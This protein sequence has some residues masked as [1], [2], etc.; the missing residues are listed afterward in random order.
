MD[1]ELRYY[2]DPVLRRKAAKVAR[3]DDEVRELVLG[4]FE[5]MRA[6]RGVGLAA[7]Q[8]GI[9]LQVV[10]LDLS[11]GGKPRGEMFGIINPV[12][13]R[14]SGSI[15]DEEGCLSFPG[16]RLMIKR[17]M[18]VRIEGLDMNGNPVALEASG[19]LARAA[20]HETDHLNGIQFFRRLPFLKL[21]AF[22][23]TLPKLKRQYRG[24]KGHPP[25][26]AE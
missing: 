24:L 9:P 23:P 3:V 26:A 17:P 5:V 6:S 13:V 21:L 20:M 7:N 18:E 14:K 25:P 15:T 2:N 11:I 12:V 1:L 22:L 10:T 16:L 8:V 4:M 19:I